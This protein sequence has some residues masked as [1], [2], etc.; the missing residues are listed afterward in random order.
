MEFSTA[1]FNALEGSSANIT[2]VRSGFL[3]GTSTIDYSIS[4]GT[5]KAGSDYIPVSGTLRFAPGESTKSF[6]VPIIYDGLVEGSETINLALGNPTGGTSR[7]RTTAML[8]IN[9]PPPLLLTDEFSLRAIALNAINSMRDPFPLV[10]AYNFGQ[11][12]RTRVALFACYVDLLPGEALSVVT[13]QAEDSQHRTYLLTV[14]FVGKVSDVNG[15]SQIVVKLPDGLISGDAFVRV[16]LRGVSS[17][18]VLIKI[19]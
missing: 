11:D 18:Q 7:G 17:N 5:A 1:N 4:D 19:K 13:A 9:D 10:T 3:T 16:Y 12:D 6:T 2:V 14:E 8:T 15:L